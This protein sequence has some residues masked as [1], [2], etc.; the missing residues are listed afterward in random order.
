MLPF[1]TTA[2]LFVQWLCW[3]EHGWY[4][5]KPLKYTYIYTYRYI[6]APL[7]FWNEAIIWKGS[8][9]VKLNEG[10]VQKE[11]VAVYQVSFCT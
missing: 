2:V 7:Y 4:F 10:Q 9:K 11:L 5:T 3:G 1:G 6:Q 8:L